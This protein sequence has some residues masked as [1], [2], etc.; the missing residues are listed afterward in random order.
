MS[1]REYIQN[2]MG[3]KNAVMSNREILRTVYKEKLDKILV[4]E[5]G[6]VKY[7]LYHN[8]NKF[9]AHMKIPSEVVPNFYYDTVIEFTTD[10]PAYA[11]G[12]SLKDYNVKFYSNDPS[13]VYTFAHA[14]LSN[15]M[16]IRDLVP[17]MSKEAVKKV[18]VEKNPKN[19]VGYVKSIFFAYLLIEKYGLFNKIQY[20]TYGKPYNKKGLLAEVEHA[21]TKIASRKTEGAKVRKRKKKDA[22]AEKTA[23]KAEQLKNINIA[24]DHSIVAKRASVI[25]PNSTAKKA[26]TVKKI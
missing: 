2:P 25:Q 11:V 7:Q 13:F 23:R 14:M 4:R 26:K 19:E 9:V 3:R 24:A 8:K 18:A 5:A 15:D 16:F 10:N 1:F 20:T 22:S 17:R 21:D 12:S 6:K